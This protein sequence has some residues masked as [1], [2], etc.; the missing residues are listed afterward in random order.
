MCTPLLRL[1]LSGAALATLF[2]P[3][4]PTSPASASPWSDRA[5]LGEARQEVAVAALGGQIY[6][7]GGFRADLTVGD[8]VEVW[9]SMSDSWGFAASLP[10]PIHH[11]TAVAVGGK[12]YVIGG[13]SDFFA[14]PLAAVYEYDPMTDTWA[15]RSSMPTA[16]GSPAAA[17]VEGKIYVTGGSPVARARDFAV[18]DPTQDAW[19]S[20]PDM[21]TGRNHLAAAGVADRFYAVGG[22]TSLGAG[23]GNVAT[24]EVFDIGAGA[25]SSLPPMPNARGGI[26]AASLDRFVFAFGGEGNQ[27]V[28][29]GVFPDVDAFDTEAG[30]W[31]SLTDMPTPRHGIG[32]AVRDGRR[33]YIPGGGPVEGF[34]VTGVHEVFDPALEPALQP[35]AVPGITVLGAGLC[36]A[37]L[38]V[39]TL[40]RH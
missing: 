23:A 27:A 3:V 40:R 28:P 22:R 14:T 5:P 31:I 35:E 6:V 13:W 38:I 29:S 32:A 20:L 19:T 10:V 7:I 26:A 2:T 36:A 33:I 8:T 25:W 24:L 39:I 9:D 4:V 12:L 17:V 37:L 15:T 34:G 30:V 21:P 11:S 1:V 16:R 18:Y